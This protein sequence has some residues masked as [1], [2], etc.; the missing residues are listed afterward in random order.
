MADTENAIVLAE[1]KLQ[2]LAKLVTDNGNKLAE[3]LKS[4]R[5]RYDEMTDAANVAAASCACH[6]IKHGNI[7]VLGTF[8][9]ALGGT[10]KTFARTNAY[11][12][13]FQK[14]CPVVYN[15][16]TKEFV[17]AGKV[18]AKAFKDRYDHDRLSMVTEM[19]SNPAYVLSRQAEYRGFDMIEVIARAVKQ[20]K[21]AL[22]K[23]PDDEKT[24]VT[25]E[26]ITEAQRLLHRLRGGNDNQMGEEEGSAA[27]AADI[28]DAVVI[29]HQDK[30]R[31]AA[32]KAA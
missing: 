14:F 28:P 15:T 17:H 8:L 29:E 11:I 21:A 10:S 16:E 9:E 23:H 19:L 5:K 3:M 26:Q 22:E 27:D 12:T 18:K 13:F 31:R 2:G 25:P 4:L 20:G 1:P 24:K 32:R 7:T 30:P 6:V